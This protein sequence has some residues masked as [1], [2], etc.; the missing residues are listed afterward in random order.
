MYVCKIK[1]QMNFLSISIVQRNQFG[2]QPYSSLAG[3][4]VL[5]CGASMFTS[6]GNMILT[7]Y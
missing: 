3:G 1:L 6:M 4:N 2:V 5:M 7:D